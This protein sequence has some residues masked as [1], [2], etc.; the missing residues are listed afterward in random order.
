MAITAEVGD[1]PSLN[2]TDQKEI[3]WPLANFA[4]DIWGDIFTSY[5]FDQQVIYALFSL[6]LF[7]RF[8]LLGLPLFGSRIFVRKREKR[9]E[10]SYTFWLTKE[11]VKKKKKSFFCL[12]FGFLYRIHGKRK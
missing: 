10:N 7:F 6:I 12:V 2:D 5:T 1:Y 8:L 9:N 4:K 3:V 11:S